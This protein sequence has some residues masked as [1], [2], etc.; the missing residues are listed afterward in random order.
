MPTPLA[1]RPIEPP[2]TGWSFRRLIAQA[3]PSDLIGV[4]GDLEPGTLLAAYREGVFPMGV[5]LDDE[6][7]LGWWSP[8]ERGVLRPANLHVSRSLRRSARTMQLSV[9]VDF[10]G[11]V[12]GCAD[13][14]RSGAWITPEIAAAYQRLHELGWAHSIEVWREG[15]LAGGLYGVAV[16]GL[17]AGESKF[18][19]VTDASKLALAGLVDVMRSG[20][21]PAL[22]DVQWRTD[23][24]ATLGI[25][26][27][28]RPDYLAAL[29]VLITAPG[30]DWAAWRGRRW[31]RR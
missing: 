1:P 8:T 13:P 29:P 27:M 22:I 2:P 20:A 10:A 28:S 15:E 31:A 14:Q 30:P 9:D 5:D 6:H 7:V 26:V 11:V 12:A 25:E 19:R 4:G 21:G 16:G 24:L 23:H 17:F 3:P 18:H